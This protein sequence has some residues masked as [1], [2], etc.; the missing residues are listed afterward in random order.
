M[1]VHGFE[2]ERAVA[3]VRPA[4]ATQRALWMTW[5]LPPER[6]CGC[7]VQIKAGAVHL[8]LCKLHGPA[9]STH[10][11]GCTRG[12]FARSCAT[13]RCGWLVLQGICDPS[14]HRRGRMLSSRNCLLN[15]AFAFTLCGEPLRTA[16]QRK[17]HPLAHASLFIQYM[18]QLDVSRDIIGQKMHICSRLIFGHLLRLHVHFSKQSQTTRRQVGLRT[19][20]QGPKVSPF[21][22]S[23]PSIP[24]S[25]LTDRQR[26]VGFRKRTRQ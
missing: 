2:R 23:K 13:R 5:I 24:V 9:T 11:P 1:G 3:V 7:A 8:H 4:S 16:V 20:K 25:H 6:V 18:R 15:R 19:I 21:F 17:F 10:T 22:P 14:H 12:P 26:S